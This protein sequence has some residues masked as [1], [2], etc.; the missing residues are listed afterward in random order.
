MGD[1]STHFSRYEFECHDGCGFAAVDV[2]LL[3]ILE[4]VR[5]FFN[6]PVTINSG[7][8]CAAH[9]DDIGSKPTS[10][11]IKGMAADIV[12]AG[13]SPERVADHL[14]H[15]YSKYGIGRYPGWTHI[16]V[17]KRR[18]RWAR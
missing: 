13:V 18:V 12:V 6:S 11:H 2:E 15:R 1:L 7:C 9:N 14:E 16:D 17:R 3:G 4:D 10:Y 5:D 8:R